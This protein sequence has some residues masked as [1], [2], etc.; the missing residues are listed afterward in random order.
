LLPERGAVVRDDPNERLAFFRPTSLPGAE[1]MAAYQSSQPWH[2]FHERYAFCVCR[3]AAAGVRYRRR[4]ALV[5]D[6]SVLVREPGETHYN[7]FVARPAEFK[8]L[9]IEPPLFADATRE[10]GCARSLHF[11]PDPIAHD[12]YLYGALARLCGSIEAGGEALEQQSWFVT[13]VAAIALHAEREAAAAELK[14]SK[15]A[16]Y[17]AKAHLKE[18]FN[19]LVSLDELA[20]VSRVSRFHLVHAFTKETGLPPHAYQMHIRVEHARGLLQRGIS[21]TGAAASVGFAD[22]SHFTRCFK[23]IMRVT[24]S[25]YAAGNR[26]QLHQEI[27]PAPLT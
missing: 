26:N 1:V 10:M 11:S 16:V 13:A 27:P 7:T 15:L 17:R 12:P 3:T 8:T 19:E 20:A 5:N 21:A 2:M 4:D 24:P 18:R 9:F 6:G 22:Q 14:S 25:D 23:R